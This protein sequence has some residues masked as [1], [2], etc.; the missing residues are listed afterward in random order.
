M[1]DFEVVFATFISIIA[2]VNPMGAVTTYAALTLGYTKKEKEQVVRKA[3]LVAFFT[4][5]VFTIAGRFIFGFFNINVNSFRIAGGIIILLIA[6][7]MVRGQTSPMKI[8][9][10]EKADHL[11]REQVGIIPLGIPLLAGPGA[12]TT[13]MIATSQNDTGLGEWP[14]IGVVVICCA[15]VMIASYLILR[16][17]DMIF[18]RIGRTGTKI[19]GRLMGLILGA[20]AVQFIVNGLKEI[21]PSLSGEAVGA[22]IAIARSVA[23]FLGC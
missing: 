22:I 4:L 15:L 23:I 12:I 19:F 5:A 7:D 18:D 20:V 14:W 21:F 16:R 10:K 6:I 11:E 8:T 9:D 1:I 17:S 13:V 3:A 2:I